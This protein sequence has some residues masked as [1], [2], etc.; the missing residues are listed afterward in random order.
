MAMPRDTQNV[1]CTIDMRDLINLVT[2]TLTLDIARRL[3]SSICMCMCR[4]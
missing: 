4:F 3:R 2:P 1:Y